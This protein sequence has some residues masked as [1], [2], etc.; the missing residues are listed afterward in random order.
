MLFDLRARGRRRT[1]Q[2]VYLGLALLFAVGFIGFGVGG[3]FGGGGVLEG[4]FGKEGGAKSGFSGQIEA[5]EKRV[6]KHPNEAEAW[7]R[8]AEVKYHEASGSEFF[9]EVTG[10]FTEKG[11]TLL[12]EVA[13][14]WSRYMAFNPPKPNAKVAQEILP[15]YGQEALNQ[16]AAAVQVLQQVVIPAKP[17]S[18]A[19]YGN[20]AAFAYQSK[21]VRVGDL[22][23]KKALALS[24]TNKRAQ[25]K[26]QLERIRRNP[27]GNP[28]NETFTATSKSGQPYQVKLGKGGKASAVP[29]PGK[30]STTKKK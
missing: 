18:A 26:E 5:A 11:K 12:N 1:V 16:P 28:E 15:I 10:K 30:T 13:S 4:L 17:P 22:A 29:L 24:P 23:S 14:D 9:N 7:A 19:L 3:G 20:L 2:V 27:S 8:L 21:N 6:K 25:V